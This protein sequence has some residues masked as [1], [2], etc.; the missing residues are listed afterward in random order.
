MA[1]G[2]KP[3]ILIVDDEAA[4]IKILLQTLKDDYELMVAKNGPQALKHV[5]SESRP[6]LILL[7]VVMPEMDGHQV[8]RELKAAP[9]VCDIPVM[10]ITSMT[11]AEDEAYGLELGAVD[12]ISKPFNPMIVKARV[13]THIELVEKKQK[14]E[15][16]L[17]N[18]LPR[19]VIQDL[20]DFGE[21]KPQ[22]FDKVTVLFS[23]VV[24]FTPLASALSPQELVDEL[25]EMFT[26][27]DEIIDIHH[28]ERIKT[29]GDAYLAVCGMPEDC[30]QH[31]EN[32]L[33][34]A[35]QFLD[36]LDKKNA[37]RSPDRQWR[38]RVGVHTGQV[39]GAVV[40]IKKYIYDVFGDAI[41]T[42]SR[43][44]HSCEPMRI[45]L[46]QA[47]YELTRS[48]FRFEA[49]PLTELKGKGEMQLYYLLR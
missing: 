38:V 17:Q 44:E 30:P 23:D 11:E 18:I 26:A 6:D 48:K 19:K 43:I 28:G 20:K 24:S 5:F 39:V 45:S 47:T 1:H 34:S 42:A 33:K 36:F 31:A 14:S 37:G 25:N 16:L 35:L 10:F 12:Y 40:G 15:R 27:F 46:S 41:N 32:I 21:T 4:N 9:G 22:C 13:R 2:K 3:T 49:R 29:I 7:D 8:C